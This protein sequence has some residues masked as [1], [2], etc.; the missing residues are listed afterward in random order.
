MPLSSSPP[1]PLWPRPLGQSTLV[2]GGANSGRAVL[3]RAAAVLAL[4]AGASVWWLDDQEDTM[5][6]MFVLNTALDNNVTPVRLDLGGQRPSHTVA[7]VQEAEEVDR[8]SWWWNLAQRHEGRACPSPRLWEDRWSMWAQGDRVLSPLEGWARCPVKGDEW[9]A[10]ALVDA[11]LEHEAALA[12]SLGFMPVARLVQ[13]P[14]FVWMSLPFAESHRMVALLSHLL[15]VR[16]DAGPPLLIINA[17]GKG[18]PPPSSTER[19]THRWS[20]VKW[21]GGDGVLDVSGQY[22]EAWFVSRRQDYL[23]VSIEETGRPQSLQD[24]W[25]DVK[26]MQEEGLVTQHPKEDPVA[27][28][29]L[30]GWLPGYRAKRL[31]EQWPEGAEDSGRKRL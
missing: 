28:P 21:Q 19:R 17:T 1:L 20:C 31:D 4:R 10:K 18:L 5:S 16:A 26:A 23:H 14:S 3:S 15:A 7:I 13:Q 6:E 27:W 30:R 9:G 29:S 22:N 24:G 12:A 2:V 25:Y 11:H 8:L